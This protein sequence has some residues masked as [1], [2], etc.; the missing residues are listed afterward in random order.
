MFFRRAVHAV[1]ICINYRSGGGGNRNHVK[2]TG[3]YNIATVHDNLYRKRHG[4]YSIGFCG[5]ILFVKFDRCICCLWSPGGEG[6]GSRG[7]VMVY[8]T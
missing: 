8:N 3:R 7:F 6:L 5:K 1:Y 2:T 4:P